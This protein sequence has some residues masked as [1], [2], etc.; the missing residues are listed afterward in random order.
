M[1]KGIKRIK[2]YIITEQTNKVGENVAAKTLTLPALKGPL[3][4]WQFP[5]LSMLTPAVAAAEEAT[6]EHQALA[7]KVVVHDD[8]VNV[9][10]TLK[11]I[12]ATTVEGIHYSLWEF[13]I[14]PGD[15]DAL[16]AVRG[17]LADGNYTVEVSRSANNTITVTYPNGAGI[18]THT[19]VP[20]DPQGIGDGYILALVTRI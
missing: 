2:S 17:P 12:R 16:L 14:T 3:G 8:T 10:M 15:A 7:K 18:S 4:I 5:I 6:S 11:F 19:W 13:Q 1:Y 9:T 20:A